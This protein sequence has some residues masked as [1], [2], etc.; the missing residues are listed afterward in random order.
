[1]WRDMRYNPTSSLN[2]LMWLL[3][4]LFVCCAICNIWLPTKTMAKDLPN[5]TDPFNVPAFFASTHAIKAHFETNGVPAELKEAQ[6]KSANYC[7]VL[8]HPYSGMDT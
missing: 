2:C 4:L 1:M 8:A 3:R 6:S 7:F 5:P